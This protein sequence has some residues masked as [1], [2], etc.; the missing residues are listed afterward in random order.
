M[1]ALS[2]IMLWGANPMESERP[3]I[4]KRAA[5]SDLLLDIILRARHTEIPQPIGYLPPFKKNQWGSSSAHHTSPTSRGPSEY[6]HQSTF[7][8]DISEMA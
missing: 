1:Q 4:M 7:M 8:P 2:L 3:F 6:Q 5:D